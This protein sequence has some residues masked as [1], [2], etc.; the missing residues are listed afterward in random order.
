MGLES[1]RELEAE[2][3]ISATA[4]NGHFDGRTIKGGR[5]VRSIRLDEGG[6]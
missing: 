4:L 3:V 1:G 2:V 6:F 5:E